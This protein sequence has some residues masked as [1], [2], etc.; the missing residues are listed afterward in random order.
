[1]NKLRRFVR[2][3]ISDWKFIIQPGSFVGHKVFDL[4]MRL[5]ELLILIPYR[6]NPS[7]RCFQLHAKKWKRILAYIV[8]LQFYIFIAWDFYHYF[9]AKAYEN[10]SFPPNTT[11]QILHADLLIVETI[12]FVSLSYFIFKPYFVQ[13]VNFVIKFDI[14][15]GRKFSVQYHTCETHRI[16]QL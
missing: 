9:H 14:R 12:A 5:P 1:M 16:L 13:Y 10:S 8:A 3:N 4:Y 11:F 7:K 15:G 6:W 2:S